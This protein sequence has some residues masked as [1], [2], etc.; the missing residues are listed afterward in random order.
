DPANA[1]EAITSAL[2]LVTP[3]AEA[4]G[5]A[6]HSSARGEAVAQYYGDGDRVRQIVVNLLSNAVKFTASGGEIHIDCGVTAEADSDIVMGEDGPY[7]FIRVRDTGIGVAPDQLEEIF[8]PFAQV[9]GGHTRTRGGT[10]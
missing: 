10:G 5:V 2:A 4:R 9:E 3:Q 1:V 8:E 7:A 6:I